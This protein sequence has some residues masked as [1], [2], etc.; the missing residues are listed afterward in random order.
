VPE[1]RL[2]LLTPPE[3]GL[4]RQL[5]DGMT[6]AEIADKRGVSRLNIDH[7]VMIVMV[8]LNVVSR[9]E[10]VAILKVELDGRPA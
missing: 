6:N 10:L 7:H 9:S 8:K 1:A 3:R 5:A 4:A 2:S